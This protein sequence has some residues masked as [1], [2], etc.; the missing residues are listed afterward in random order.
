MLSLALIYL[1]MLFPNGRLI[2]RRWLPFALIG[3]MGAL[4]VAL[5]GA[6]ADKLVVSYDTSFKMDNPI[7]IS[8]LASVPIT[9]Y[10]RVARL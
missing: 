4:G 7:G 6:L 8:R 10:R 1:P 5:L 9:R 2:S 3:G